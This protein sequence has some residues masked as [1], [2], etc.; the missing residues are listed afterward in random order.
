MVGSAV[1]SGFMVSSGI[2]RNCQ[3]F[4]GLSFVV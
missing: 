4:E 1:E 2:L 3:I